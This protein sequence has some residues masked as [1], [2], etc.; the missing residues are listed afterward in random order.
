MG[1]KGTQGD[2]GETRP[3]GCGPSEELE[4]VRLEQIERWQ[5]LR[6]DKGQ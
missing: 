5:G 3:L 6:L 1:P 4:T 2:K